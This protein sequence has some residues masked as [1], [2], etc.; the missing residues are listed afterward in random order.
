M[1]TKPFCNI[2]FLKCLKAPD[3]PGAFKHVRRIL[4]AHYTHNIRIIKYYCLLNTPKDVHILH[5]KVYIFVQ[6]VNR[7][8]TP[9]DVYY[10]HNNVTQRS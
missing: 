1:I 4:S 3:Y 8:Y 2:S 6:N 7:I 5:L 9:V 10:K